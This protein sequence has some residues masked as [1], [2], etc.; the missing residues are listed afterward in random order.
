MQG[1]YLIV[2]RNWMAWQ[3]I[4]RKQKMRRRKSNVRSKSLLLRFYWKKELENSSIPLSQALPIKALGFGF[5]ACRLRASWWMDSMGWMSAKRCGCSW[6]IQM[7]SADLSISKKLVHP[8]M[9]KQIETVDQMTDKQISAK[10][11]EIG[12]ASW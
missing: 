1:L 9:D 4:A 2:K 7:F 10:V 5:S 8:N 3:L 11:C 12:R 6:S